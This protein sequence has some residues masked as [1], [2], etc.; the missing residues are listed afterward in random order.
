[1]KQSTTVK[2]TVIALALLLLATI[3]APA[4]STTRR[5]HNVYYVKTATVSTIDTVK[6]YVGFTDLQGSEW[7]WYCDT[8]SIPWALSET[9]FLVM[10]NNGSDYAYDD[11]IVSITR[12]GII[13]D[14]V[15]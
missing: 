15:S 9:V 11:S 13:S 10:D 8:H 2:I 7:Y 14:V 4:C 5:Q 12:E 3:I 1:M 6:Q